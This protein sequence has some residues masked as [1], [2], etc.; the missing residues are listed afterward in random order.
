VQVSRAKD[1]A[2][3][4]EET[5]PQQAGAVVQPKKA[6]LGLPGLLAAEVRD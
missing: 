1:F 2:A 6:S 5:V 4:T 3:V